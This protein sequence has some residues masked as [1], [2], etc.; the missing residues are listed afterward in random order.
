VQKGLARLKAETEAEVEE[1]Y[2]NKTKLLEQ[3]IK[4]LS[5]VASPTEDLSPASRSGTTPPPAQPELIESFRERILE[6]ENKLLSERKSKEQL[7][8]LVS[9]LQKEYIQYKTDV[10]MHLESNAAE[11]VLLQSRLIEQSVLLADARARIDELT[12]VQR[13]TPSPNATT[14][15]RGGEMTQREALLVNENN[16]LREEI[17]SL[18]VS[19]HAD[20]D[21]WKRTVLKQ[22][23]GEC[24]KYR[25]RLKR[26]VM[27]PTSGD[28]QNEGT[29]E[30]EE[31]LLNEKELDYLFDEVDWT[32]DM[33]LLEMTP[34]KLRQHVSN[35]NP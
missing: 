11:Q 13:R 21:N 4:A 35:H 8:G 12:S 14:G 26:G 27:D 25:Q 31:N 9:S 20:F 29:A 3:E 18:K 6:L 7:T 23:R 19:M 33:Q 24:I 30:N 1:R 28:G 5:A 22:V 34:E 32:G 15:R 2:S 17:D 16:H 10:E